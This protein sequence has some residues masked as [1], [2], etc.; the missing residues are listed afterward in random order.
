MKKS[1]LLICLAVIAC[2]ETPQDT[3]LEVDT[4]LHNGKIATIDARLSIASAVAVTGDRIVAVGGEEILGE[5]VADNTVD[6]AGRFVMPGFIDSHTHLRGRPQR[7]IDLT[8]TTSIEEIKGLV[9]DKADELGSG[10]WVTGYGWSEDF[11][12]ELR[13]PLRADLDE[14]APDNPVMLTRAGG[15]RYRDR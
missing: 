5:Y 12:A 9:R 8:K 7:F 4:I 14:A 15:R 2:S 11:M 3:R 10:E 1:L 6:L 13:R